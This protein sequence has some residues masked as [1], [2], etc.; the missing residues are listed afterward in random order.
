VPRIDSEAPKARTRT[1]SGD[2]PPSPAQP[3]VEIYSQEPGYVVAVAGKYLIQV[4]RDRTTTTTISLVRRALS[5]LSDRHATFGYLCI[6]E[7][8]A[9]LTL[10]PAIRE[11]VHAFVRRYTSRFTGVAVVLEK[12]GFQGT[13]VRSVMTAINVASRATHPSQVFDKLPEAASWLNRLTLGG[14]TTTGLVQ[15]AKQLRSTT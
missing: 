5:D 14:L 11:G 13:A 6:L 15:V 8:E 12:A 3:A 10:P 1:K 9:Q 4:L 7:P 2:P